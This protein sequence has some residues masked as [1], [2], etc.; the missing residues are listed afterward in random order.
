MGLPADVLVRQEH[1]EL[2]REAERHDGPEQQVDHMAVEQ[3]ADHDVAEVAE[4]DSAGSRADRVRRLEEPR[5]KPAGEHH[6]RGE[7]GELADAT[8]RGKE[9]EDE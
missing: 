5:G 8:V 6:D 9:P 7:R 4:H 1:R 2:V 3:A